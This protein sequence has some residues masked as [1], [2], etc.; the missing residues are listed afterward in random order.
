MSDPDDIDD[1]IPARSS[2]REGPPLPF[3]WE[4]LP[5]ES[6]GRGGYRARANQARWSLT[7]ASGRVIHLDSLRQGHTNA[8]VLCGS[9]RSDPG[10]NDRRVKGAIE[11]AARAFHR[12][13]E[14]IAVLPPLLLRSLEKRP[15]REA[16]PEEFTVDF[17]PAV[18][19]LAMFE[20]DPVDPGEMFSTLPV[21]WFQDAWGLPEAGHVTQ[22]LRLLDWER[23]AVDGSW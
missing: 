15:P 16:G 3:A 18:Q 2:S 13:P 12:E 11:E 1:E 5:R 8:G 14:K 21:V 22:Q 6:L 7:L 17:L 10:F 19:T 4:A 9:P 23:L 20:S